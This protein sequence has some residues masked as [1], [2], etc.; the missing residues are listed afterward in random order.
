M[1]SKL[2]IKANKLEA[3]EL[4]KT[5]T[6]ANRKTIKECA[7]YRKMIRAYTVAITKMEKDH[8][9]Y[10]AKVNRRIAILEGRNDA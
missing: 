4:R 9:N 3:K 10:A 6:A 8:S 7:K 2:E 1:P 5:L